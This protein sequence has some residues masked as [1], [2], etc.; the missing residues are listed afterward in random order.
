MVSEHAKRRR[1]GYIFKAP[2]YEDSFIAQLA[3]SEKSLRSPESTANQ[4]QT[5]CP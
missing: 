1:A 4:I 3:S 5:R 2:N